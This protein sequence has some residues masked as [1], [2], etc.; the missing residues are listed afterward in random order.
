MQ[1]ST[2]HYIKKMEKYLKCPAM[3]IAYAIIFGAYG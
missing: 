2:F 1:G 3:K